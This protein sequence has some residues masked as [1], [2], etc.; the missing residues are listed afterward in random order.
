VAEVRILLCGGTG[1]LGGYL[2]PQLIASGHEVTVLVRTDAATRIAESLGARTARGDI[3]ARDTVVAAAAGQDAVIHGVTQIP[4]SFPG[5]PDEFAG[6]DRVRREG[7]ANLL[8]AAEAAGVRRVVLQSIIWVHGDRGPDWIHEDAPL[9]PSRMTRSAAEL[10]AQ[11]RAFGERTGAAVTILRCGSLYSA[12]SWHTREVLQRLRA[13][14]LPLIGDG[15]NF[16]SFIHGADMAA[17]FAAAA[18]WDGSG[19]FF[20]VDDEPVWLATYLRWLAN[21]VGASAPLHIPGFMARLG[22]GGEMAAAYSSSVRCRND[23]I[24][25]ALA[26]TPRYPTFREGYA[27]VLPRIG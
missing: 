2:V 9:E 19:T 1:V 6:N 24:K 10:E 21:A 17:A 8:A 23:R 26:W 14:T 5:K 12:E 15:Q 4:R 25:Q 27:E 20:V 13:R 22:L 3:L 7:T 11:G 16:Q 18:T